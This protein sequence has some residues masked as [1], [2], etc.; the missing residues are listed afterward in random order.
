MPNEI[1]PNENLPL[2]TIVLF[3]K[4]I[5]EFKNIYFTFYQAF[6]CPHKAFNYY[7]EIGLIRLFFNKK[8]LYR[9]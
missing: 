1:V 4:K 7:P 9:K 6:I 3:W 2:W 8:Y 5:F